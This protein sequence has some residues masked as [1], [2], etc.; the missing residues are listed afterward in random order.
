MGN[1]AA[2]L[3]LLFE[4]TV[5]P[6]DWI[7][8]GAYEG[9]VKSLSIRATVLTDFDRRDVVI[10]NRTL[11]SEIVVNFTRTDQ[12]GRAIIKVGVAYGSDTRLVDQLLADTVRSHA[13]VEDALVTFDNFGDNALNFTVRVYLKDISQRLGVVNEIHHRVT[14]VF[15]RHNIEISF[16]QR[17]LHIRDGALEVRLIKPAE[18]SEGAQEP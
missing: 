14:D 12:T 6:G 7:T 11:I 13:L 5:R 9:I 15:R 16:P 10:P 18:L 17:D 3:A 2:G 8:V 4:R 1:F